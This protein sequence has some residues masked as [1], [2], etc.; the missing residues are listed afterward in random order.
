MIVVGQ[1]GRAVG[2]ARRAALTIATL[3]L[4]AGCGLVGASSGTS[5]SVPNGM[6]VTSPDVSDGV[7]GTTY[8]CHG[9]GE[10]PGLHWS[11][12]PADASIAVVMDDASAPITPYIYWIMFDIKPETTDIPTGTPPRG[13][14]EA[15]NSAGTLKYD[16][17][18]PRGQS[19]SYRFTV[20]ALG[21]PISLPKGT[22]LIS[23]WTAIAQAAIRWGRLTATA[24]P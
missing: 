19:H 4:L 1:R 23:A 17:P 3:P 13:A 24:D 14:R 6:T 22:S 10:S 12:A 21:K 16:P 5:L 20:Y 15:V 9:S 18:C 2:G 7:L 8:T 11:G